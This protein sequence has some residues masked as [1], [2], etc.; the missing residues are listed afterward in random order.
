MATHLSSITGIGSS[1]KKLAALL[2]KKAP[3]GEKLAFINDREAALLKRH[4]GSGK[5][6]EDT[7][8]KSYD[9]T[10]G[11]DLQPTNVATGAANA[12][13]APVSGGN[14]SGAGE[15]SNAPVDQ[16]AAEPTETGGGNAGQGFTSSTG[17]GQGFTSATGGGLGISAPTPSAGAPSVNYGLNAPSAPQAADQFG[18]TSATGTPQSAISPDITQAV[19]NA[20][21]N[22]S[23][24]SL[25]DYLSQPKNLVGAGLGGIQALLGASQIR[26]AEAQGQQAKQQ[27]QALAAPYQQQ[28]QQLQAQ[29]NAGTLTPANQQALQAAQAQLAQQVQARG[30][31]GAQQ[32]QTQIAALTNNLLQQQMNLGLQMQ[33]IGDK[34][35]QGAITAGVQADQYVNQLTSNYAN[36]IAKT[37]FGAVGGGNTSSPT[38]GN[39]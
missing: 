20:G 6:V 35:A 12:D 23:T 37:V 13:L 38:G 7:G 25:S 14:Q 28:G 34:I 5:E 33:Q 11:F 29:A 18:L 30:G 9:D 8:I 22:K 32:M 3:A 10:E 16:A 17:G 26:K 39:A 27:T 36:N 1:A 24:Q 21:A 4:G 2:Q 19:Q 31:V 15:V